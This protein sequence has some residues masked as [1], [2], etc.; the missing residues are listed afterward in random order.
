ML[1]KEFEVKLTTI[2]FSTN[3]IP[4]YESQVH[5]KFFFLNKCYFDGFRSNLLLKRLLNKITEYF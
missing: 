3:V 1:F 5:P 4:M 2:F